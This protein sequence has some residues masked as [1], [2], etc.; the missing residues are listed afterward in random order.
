MNKEFILRVLEELVQNPFLIMA[1]M[2]ATLVVVCC[3][4]EQVINFIKHIKTW[5][6]NL[7]KE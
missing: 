2:L 3:T 4:L 7:H 5:Y 6:N 1:V